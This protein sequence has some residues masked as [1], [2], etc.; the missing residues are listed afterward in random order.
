MKG[1]WGLHLLK[2]D[3]GIKDEQNISG[4]ITISGSNIF[5]KEICLFATRNLKIAPRLT[6]ALFCISDRTLLTT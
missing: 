5:W 3:M 4:H 6:R 2:A 1:A